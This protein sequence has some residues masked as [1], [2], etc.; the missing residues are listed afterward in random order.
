LKWQTI[1]GTDANKATISADSNSGGKRV[2]PEK[3]TPTGAIEN[4]FELVFELEA[5]ATTD[6]TLYFKILDPDNFIGLGNFDPESIWPDTATSWLGSDNYATLSATTSSVTI[7][8]GTTSATL[9]IVVYPADYTGTKLTGNA[10]TIVIDTAHAGDNFIVVADTDQTKTN[11][12]ALGTTEAT[13]YKESHGYEQTE[14]LTVWRTLWMELDQMATP[15]ATAADGLALANQG[16]GEGNWDYTAPTDE[17]TNFDVLAQPA[18]PDISLLT[19]A[20]MAAC[21]EVKEVS[22]DPENWAWIVGDNG[23]LNN[24]GWRTE[25]PFV[26]K[27]TSKNVFFCNFF[28][29]RVYFCIFLTYF[30][31]RIFLF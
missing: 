28:V 22:Q 29:M 9:T 16:T 30:C 1:T 6:T 15:T 25:T 21:I 3:S 24:G 10:E 13:R 26:H 18:K 17:P 19:T 11:A 14:L 5:A 8:T 23:D 12:A 20:M 27:G 31:F 2:F 7:A 4:K